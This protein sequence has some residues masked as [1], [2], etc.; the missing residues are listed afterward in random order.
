MK[1]IMSDYLSAEKIGSARRGLANP[2]QNTVG[3]ANPTGAIWANPLFGNA[4]KEKINR[5]Y[6]APTR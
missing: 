1:I 4:T 6:L 2:R 3:F 5:Y